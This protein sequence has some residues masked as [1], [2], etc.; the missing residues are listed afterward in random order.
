MAKK[1]SKNEIRR[2]RSPR[3]CEAI[4]RGR[5]FD[6]KDPGLLIVVA[7]ILCPVD[8]HLVVL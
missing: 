5:S 3:R 6:A 2:Y 1:T 8:D 4:R 7:A